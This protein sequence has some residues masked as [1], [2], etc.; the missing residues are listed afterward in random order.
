[1][2]NVLRLFLKYTV[3][4]LRAGCKSGNN[5]F[6][7]LLGSLNTTSLVACFLHEIPMEPDLVTYA[8]RLTEYGG[9]WHRVKHPQ[10]FN[11]DKKSEC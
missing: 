10:P 8:L 7:V 9:I 5:D 11:F 6:F 3:E 1:M 2:Q 4:R